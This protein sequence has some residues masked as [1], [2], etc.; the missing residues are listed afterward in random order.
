MK[1][2]NK[3]LNLQVRYIKE[4]GNYLDFLNKFRCRERIITDGKY[5][6]SEE[7]F[8]RTLSRFNPMFMFSNVMGDNDIYNDEFGL[9]LY[10]ICGK[11]ISD[12]FEKFLNENSVHKLFFNNVNVDFII[13]NSKF[14]KTK[15][16]KACGCDNRGFIYHNLCPM[17]YFMNAFSW[18]LTYQGHDFWY[19]LNSKWEK[20][21]MVFINS[22]FSDEV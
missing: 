21:L 18:S 16:F 22:L 8:I 10:S 1:F 15:S 7:D 17:A 9:Y 3:L 19:K 4:R 11:E 20:A 13:R 2:G 6:L 5:L 12:F 14:G